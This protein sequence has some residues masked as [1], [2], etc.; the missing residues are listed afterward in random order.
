MALATRK[1][2]GRTHVID[3]D[4]EHRR[5]TFSLSAKFTA[6]NTGVTAV[7]GASGSGKS[8]LLDLLVGSLRP[9]RGRLVIG[10]R[11]L[12]DTSRGIFIPP[13]RRA[14]GWVPQEGLLF[15]HLDVA[16]NLRFGAKRSRSAER[17]DESRVIDTLGLSALLGRWPRDLSGGERQ[18]VA[19]G[20]ALLAQPDIL[21]LDEPLAAVDAPRKFEILALLESI[22]RE[23]RTP[24]LHVTHSLAEV[25]RLADHLVLI[26]EGRILA[27]GAI[28]DLVGRLDTPLLPLRADAGSL[29]TLRPRNDTNEDQCVYDLE[30]QVV[31]IG[32]RSSKLEG[33]IRAYVSAS[34][35]ILA[36]QR[37]EGLSVRNMLQARVTRLR[38]RDDGSV[39]VE[40]AVGSQFLL[41][42]VTAAAAKAL[43]LS[44]GHEVFALIK[45][46]SLDA[47][48]GLRLLELG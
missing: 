28:N 47:P 1:S 20:R 43:G 42:A 13:E 10:E 21:L 38:A 3:V 4:L 40:L 18:R 41:A 35:V 39:L 2:L 5:G 14:V 27:S 30:G 36:T 7:F 24:I 46:L 12:I 19:L 6:P 11:V 15:P 37:P 34:E 23:F 44:P 45:S 25:L 31:Q 33:Q 22:K 16:A 8:T 17:L 9:D 29:L 48:A 32:S 26:D